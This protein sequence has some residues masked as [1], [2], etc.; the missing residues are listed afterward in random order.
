MGPNHMSALNALNTINNLG[1]L[2]ADQGKHA[3]AE[4]M[5]QRALDG[6]EK[7]WS[8][9]HPLTL[10]TL[11]NLKLLNA[12]R[13]EHTKVEEIQPCADQSD[14]AHDTK[15]HLQPSP[16]T[17]RAVLHRFKAGMRRRK[18]GT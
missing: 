5:Y 12:G 10:R 11:N 18:R 7:A 2:Y 17:A 9:D 1:V 4:E 14:E 8:S 6:Y 15:H 3:E 16:L 13:S